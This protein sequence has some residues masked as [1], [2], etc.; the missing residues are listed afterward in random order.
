LLF[1]GRHEEAVPSAMQS[2]RFAIDIYGLASIELVPSYLTLGEAC[3]GIGQLTQADEY[4]SQAQ[5]TVLKTPNCSNTIKSKLYRNIGLL[6]A[7][8]GDFEESLYNFANDVCMHFIN[9][10]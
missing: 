5:W 6:Y 9:S 10:Y 7:A 2:L 1:E 3:T 4:L 8:K